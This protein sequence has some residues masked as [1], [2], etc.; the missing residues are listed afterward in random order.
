MYVQF[1]FAHANMKDVTGKIMLLY[2]LC[3]KF[4]FAL[5][6]QLERI[7]DKYDKMREVFQ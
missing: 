2:I 7:G 3:G 1:I 6:V 4:M 5:K